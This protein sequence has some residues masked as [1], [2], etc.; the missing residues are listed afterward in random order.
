VRGVGGGSGGERRRS[1]VVVVTMRQ[2]S[3]CK[4]ANLGNRITLSAHS[5]AEQNRA[6]LQSNALSDVGLRVIRKG[7]ERHG[8]AL[9]SGHWEG[10]AEHSEKA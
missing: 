5:G 8:Q 7:E 1:V 6:V 3:V 10:S 2:Q 9:H 4:R